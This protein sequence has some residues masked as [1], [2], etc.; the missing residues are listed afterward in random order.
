MNVYAKPNTFAPKVSKLTFLS[1][2]TTEFWR[3]RRSFMLWFA[4]LS[5]LLLALPMLL[6]T[7]SYE[8]ESPAM[9]WQAF[10]G[11]TLEF[12]GVMMPIGA[13]ILAALSVQ[14][15][16]E[17]WRF[18]LA[19]EV[20]PAQLFLAKFAGL[21]QLTLLSSFVLFTN[22]VLGG[23]FLGVL[24]IANVF[25]AAFL[26]W[27]VG[28]GVL[29]LFLTLSLMTGLG[30]TI[31]VGVFGMLSGALLADKSIWMYVPFAWPMRVILPIAEIYASGIPLPPESPLN[32]MS[33]IPVA[34]V[35]SVIL[36]VISL[37]LGAIYLSRKEI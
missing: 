34:L 20:K 18:L 4:L 12:W 3:Y 21:A 7:L 19:Y 31:G 36:G 29:A 28:L 10:Q 23:L 27:V 1:L 26:P 37:T 24:D 15:D 16:R 22:L 6:L 8:G 17:A 35:L 25:L 11:T 2:V 13:A 30:L 32:D 9:R 33:V 14:Q 5:P